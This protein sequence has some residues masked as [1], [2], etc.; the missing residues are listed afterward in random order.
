M[1]TTTRLMLVALLSLPLMAACDKAPTETTE[2]AAV[3]LAPLSAPTTND[4]NEWGTYLSAV[5]T[6]NMG[7]VTSS[8]YLYYLPSSDSEGF[9][10]A[11][12]RLREEIQNAMQRG[13]V[14]GN[15]VA[16]GSP[17]S[18][19]MADIIVGAFEKVGPGSMKGV[20][21]LFIGAPADSERVEQAVSPAGV[22]YVFVE[23]K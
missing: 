22:D 19:M 13:I 3:A 2:D 4:D 23:A 1:N 6:R 7:D 16:F 11:H 21:L 9:E 14:E 20:R 17:E 8:P 10:G 5:V 15:L 18:A 12:E